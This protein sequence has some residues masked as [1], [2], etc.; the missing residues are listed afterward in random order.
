MMAVG[1]VIQVTP[2]TGAKPFLTTFKTAS[3]VL[4]P[5]TRALFIKNTTIWM[6]AIT[7]KLVASIPNF[8]LG[9][10]R[11]AKALCIVLAKV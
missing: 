1:L 10:V 5:S 3:L 2:K 6:G 4:A 11:P 8:A 9:P 7:S